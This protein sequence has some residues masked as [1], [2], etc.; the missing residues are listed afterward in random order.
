MKRNRFI[1]LAVIALLV[2]ASLGMMAVRAFASDTP[3]TSTLPLQSPAVSQ[4]TQ[5]PTEQT[6]PDV[7]T[8]KGPDNDTVEVQEGDQSGPDTGTE[9]SDGTEATA[10]AADPAVSGTPAITADA[11][12]ASAEAALNA[13]SASQVSLDDE[14]GKLVYS[15]QIGNSDV[16]VDA[17]TG[18]VLGTESGED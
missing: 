13:G 11:A 1:S 6:A 5:A 8:V 16:K 12:K 9:V 4:A 18:S 2:M 7:E 17:M 3:T 10:E 15:V 14:N